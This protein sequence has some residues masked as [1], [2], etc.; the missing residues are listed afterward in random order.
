[1]KK[2]GHAKQ[3]RDLGGEKG[4]KETLTPEELH[5]LTLVSWNFSK[6]VH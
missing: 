3:S 6:Y 4:I 5:D 2:E 1:M